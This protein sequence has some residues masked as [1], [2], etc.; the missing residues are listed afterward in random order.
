MLPSRALE[1]ACD[2]T[3]E[4]LPKVR[5]LAPVVTQIAEA[6]VACW[7][8]GGKIL[9]AG[10]GGSAADALHFS[11]ELTVRYKRDR[12]PLAS[13]ALMDVTAITCSGNDHGYNTIFSRQIEALGR[14][15]A[16]VWIIEGDIMRPLTDAE[17]A[18]LEAARP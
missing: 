14:A 15:G 11:E 12:R 3:V 17:L 18:S 8:G 16:P 5:L 1:S 10:N 13:I 2:E 4:L 9:M 6:M 7:D